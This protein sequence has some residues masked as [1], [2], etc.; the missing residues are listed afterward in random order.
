MTQPLSHCSAITS[1]RYDTNLGDSIDFLTLYKIYADHQSILSVM[2]IEC[3][4]LSEVEKSTCHKEKWSVHVLAV[5]GPTLVC[6]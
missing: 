6:I 3:D 4:V 5:E 1:S 2:F